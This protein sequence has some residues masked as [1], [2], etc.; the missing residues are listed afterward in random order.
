V[1]VARSS[2]RSRRDITIAA[3]RPRLAANMM[4]LHT[5]NK[6]SYKGRYFYVTRTAAKKNRGEMV[7]IL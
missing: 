5:P 3:N 1:C 7:Q 2:T 6:Q 4:A